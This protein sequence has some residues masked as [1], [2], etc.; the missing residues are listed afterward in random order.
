MFPRSNVKIFAIDIAVV[1]L[2]HARQEANEEPTSSEVLEA[3]YNLIEVIQRQHL[4]GYVTYQSQDPSF[5]NASVGSL[6][7][8]GTG[9]ADGLTN[10]MEYYHIGVRCGRLSSGYLRS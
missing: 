8:D 10:I 7:E 3:C 9:R 6:L 1:V 4:L 5:T 2:L